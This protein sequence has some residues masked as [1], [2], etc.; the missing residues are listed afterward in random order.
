MAEK[1]FNYF[2]FIL[3]KH[4]DKVGMIK[5][6]WY[7]E[8]D[9]KDF[10]QIVASDPTSISEGEG[11][12]VNVKKMGKYS[13]WLLQLFLSDKLLLEDLYKVTET[14][15]IHKNNIHDITKSNKDWANVFNFEDIADLYNKIKQYDKPQEVDMEEVITNRYYIENDQATIVYEDN[16]WLVVTPKTVEASA[17]YGESTRWCT[18]K[19]GQ[20]NSYNTS[21]PL[22]IFV[23]KYPKG[24][25]E[26]KMQLSIART[27]FMDMDDSS[28]SL[29]RLLPLRDHIPEIVGEACKQFGF[30]MLR[31]DELYDALVGEKFKDKFDKLMRDY[32]NGIDDTIID[33][34]GLNVLLKKIIKFELLNE[35]YFL[36][37]LKR[38]LEHLDID[39]VKSSMGKLSMGVLKNLYINS[40]G[41]FN[42]EMFPDGG[43]FSEHEF[44]IKEKI[45]KEDRFDMRKLNDEISKSGG[46][47]DKFVD[48]LKD[49]GRKW[50][51]K[52]LLDM[53]DSNFDV[54]STGVREFLL[55]FREDIMLIHTLND[56][57]RGAPFVIEN[58]KFKQLGELLR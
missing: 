58:R 43:F 38:N 25:A 19:P 55:K 8:I 32:G 33:A 50:R 31:K 10:D 15:I 5:V 20:F 34:K 26:D 54:T 17:F 36:K 30:V 56:T 52:F 23:K 11:E 35:K 24:D 44:F 39:L 41:K 13:K 57:D 48:I 16:D 53:I 4:S 40:N 37:F 42:R 1:M 45:T 47:Y 12:G 9:D 49:K 3:E 29:M 14:L 51:L 28:I 22:Y 7:P 18:T 27:Q 46:K 2:D 6:K 21:G